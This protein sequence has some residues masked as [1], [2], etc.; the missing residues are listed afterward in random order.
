MSV[1]QL[2][3]PG[4]VYQVVLAHISGLADYLKKNHTLPYFSV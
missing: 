2:L 4:K 3:V 1:V